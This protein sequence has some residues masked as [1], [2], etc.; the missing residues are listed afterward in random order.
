MTTEIAVQLTTNTMQAIE[1]E[2]ERDPRLVSPHTKRGYK[3]DLAQFE[4]WRDGRALSKLLVEE[5][6]AHLQTTGRAATGINRALAAIR[7]WSRKVSDLVFED[8]AVDLEMRQEIVTQAARVASITDVHGK[9]AA[10]A[11]REI[12]PGEIDAL[13]RACANDHSPAGARDAAALAIGRALGLRRAELAGLQLSDLVFDGEE[14]KVTIRG[15]GGKERISYLTNGALSAVVDW[16]AIRGDDPGP[17]LCAI[18]RGGHVQ[19]GTGISTEA[20]AVLLAKRAQQASLAQSLTWHD[21]RRTFVGDLLAGGIDVATVQKL[22]GHAS[23]VT[24]T[25]YDRRPEATRKSALR[26]LH[27]PYYA[28][29]MV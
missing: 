8:P 26:S 21:L 23:P 3:H 18:R 12:T 25:R 6:A 22:A 5:Y 14:C 27:V 7:W 2:I 10:P 4:N 17:L 11:G 28:R 13:M 9:Q 19:P 20:L 1:R 24:T 16:L 15:K 29:R